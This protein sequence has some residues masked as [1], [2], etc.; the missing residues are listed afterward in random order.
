MLSKDA[1]TPTVNGKIDYQYNAAPTYGPGGFNPNATNLN[2]IGYFTEGC[3]AA[4]A[5]G[6][7][8]ANT[9]FPYWLSIINDKVDCRVTFVE[10]C[11]NDNNNYCAQFTWPTDVLDSK[12]PVSG[13]PAAYTTEALFYAQSS[14]F[15][16]IVMVQWSNVFACKSRKVNISLFR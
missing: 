14:Y 16:T 13:L 7:L 9:N 11:A 3:Q 4:I 1:Y 2:T 5:N 12:S 10:C 8:A 6:N 15:V